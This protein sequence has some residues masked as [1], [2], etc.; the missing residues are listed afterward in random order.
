MVIQ[1]QL[2]TQMNAPEGLAYQTKVVEVEGA[3]A[4]EIVAVVLVHPQH[5]VRPV[6]Q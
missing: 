5:P 3:A 6:Q 4:A 1:K 2:V